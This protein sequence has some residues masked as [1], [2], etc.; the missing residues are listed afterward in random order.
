MARHP[1]YPQDL[2]LH[3]YTENTVDL[4]TLFAGFATGVSIILGAALLLAQRRRPS[5]SALDRFLVLWFVLSGS[6]HCFFEGYFILN[7]ARMPAA[8]DFF[9]QLWKE[10]AKS[11]SRYLAA[12]PMVLTLET[13]TVLVW[14][15]LSF[16][17]SWCIVSE[18]PHRLSLQALVSTGH[19]YSDT[20]YYVTSILDMRR[21]V[22]HSRPE[23]LYFWVYFVA[24]NA[25]WII[26]PAF[27]LYQS[28]TGSAQAV[29]TTKRLTRP[30]LTSGYR[31]ENPRITAMKKYKALAR[32]QSQ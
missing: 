6:L 27:I 24:M 1:Y 21:G 18:S 31:K 30:G 9:G 19:L 16:L 17:T 29:A 12:D 10:Y 20:L 2:Q 25:L 11:D 28:I 5:I 23:A 3:H 26:V 22:L 7:H 14:G 4:A 15:P 8:Q 32:S 13:I